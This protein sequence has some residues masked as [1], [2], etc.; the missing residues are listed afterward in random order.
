MIMYY[1][2]PLKDRNEH[3]SVFKSPRKSTLINGL[4]LAGITK[5]SLYE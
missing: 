1:C 5:P 2:E 4:K 3:V